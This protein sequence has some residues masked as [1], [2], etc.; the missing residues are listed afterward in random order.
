M[1]T[2]TAGKKKMYSG[3][4]GVLSKSRQARS[5]TCQEEGTK[6]PIQGGQEGQEVAR[7]VK[8]RVA[9]ARTWGKK[10]LNPHKAENGGTQMSGSR[11]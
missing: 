2:G 10:W 6:T 4:I 5:R 8:V 3:N 7:D 9:I 11:G 1:R